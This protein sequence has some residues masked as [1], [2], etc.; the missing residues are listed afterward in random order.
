MSRPIASDRIWT[1]P[2][3]VSFLRLLGVAVFWWVL[4]VPEDIAL[5]GWLIFLIGWTDWI[6]G[7]LARRLNQESELGKVLD[8]VADR[9][10][11]ASAVIGGLVVG[12]VPPVVGWL[13]IAR[14]VLMGAVTLLLARR[15]AERLE[16]RWLG[17]AATFVLYGAIPAFYI[18]EAGFLEELF[19]PVAWVTAIVGLVL[20]WY[21]ALVYL[22]DARRN[23]SAVESPPDFEED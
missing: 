10:M 20:Y 12:V 18:A 16:V 17:K 4:L 9:L 7:Y 15:G 5:A 14:E 8:P 13:L 23:L 11:I 6:D 22:G 1:I 3:L 19:F 2:N 21:V